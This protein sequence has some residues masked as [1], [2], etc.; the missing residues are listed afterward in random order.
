LGPLLFLLYINDLAKVVEPSATPIMFAD[1]TSIM[2]KNNNNEQLQSELNIV[3]SRINEWFQEN[4]ITLNLNKTY[5]IQFSNKGINNSDIQIKI[6]NVNIA[7][8]NEIKFSWKG[9][10]DYIIP[11]FN[12]ACYCMRTVKPYVHHN[13]LKI[14]YYS[15]F[16]SVRTYGLIFWG[17]SM[18]IIKIFRLQKRIIRIMMGCKKKT[19]HAEN[20]SI[21]L[22]YCLYPPSIFSAYL[23]FLVKTKNNL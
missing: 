16:H 20:Y 1:D 18:E 23:Y 10:I 5:F 13:T 9:H 11:R 14:I 12:S 17:S 7:T 21:S 19:N 3:M 15:H 4:L 8:I 2:M 22:E 6:A